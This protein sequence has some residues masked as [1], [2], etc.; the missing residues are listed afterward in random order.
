MSKHTSLPKW[1]S[2]ARAKR[3]G[4]LDHPDSLSVVF[5]GEPNSGKSSV[6]ELCETNGFNVVE[7]FAG[8]IIKEKEKG[9]HKLHPVDGCL[10]EFNEE[11]FH[12]QVAAETA[13]RRLPLV[14]Y[15]RY[16]YDPEPY[17]WDRGI[18]A[19]DYLSTLPDRLCDI[20]FVFAPV[21][22]WDSNG[23]CEDPAWAKKLRPQ[24]PKSYSARGVITIPVPLFACED[25][26]LSDQE[27]IDKSVQDR[28]EH[29][30]KAIKRLYPDV[31]LPNV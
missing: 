1:L 17:F 29:V 3:T 4:S 27:R 15:D 23:R 25:K 24:F 10:Y 16:Y 7:E 2:E 5:T 20:A 6:A 31:T 30:I 28:Y 22:K 21:P 19:P 14:I 18:E 11:N 8:Q 26:K 9:L 13:V 12:R